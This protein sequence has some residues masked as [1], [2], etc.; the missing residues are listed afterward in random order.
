MEAAVK[1]RV[2]VNHNAKNVLLPDSTKYSE[3]WNEN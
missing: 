2:I 1:V 3:T